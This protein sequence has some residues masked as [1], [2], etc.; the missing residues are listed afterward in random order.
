[1]KWLYTLIAGVETVFGGGEFLAAA[2]LL[3]GRI[4]GR[5][6]GWFAF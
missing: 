6:A 3:W 4:L 2:A 1:M 5:P